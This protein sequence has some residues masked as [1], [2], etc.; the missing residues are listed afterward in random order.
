MKKAKRKSTSPRS[1]NS[2]DEY[3]GARMRERRD[4][5]NISQTD[6]GKK[7][8]VSFQQIQKYEKGVNR[9]SAG[10]LFDICKVLNV[11]LSSMFER[12]PKT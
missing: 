9:V 10:R 11:S 4:A 6:L 5:L 2:I 3:I 8:G 1:A 7:L 12:D